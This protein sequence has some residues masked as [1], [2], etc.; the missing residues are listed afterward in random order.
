MFP[1][2]E[3]VGA[4]RMFSIMD[5][6]NV[7]FLAVVSSGVIFIIPA[8]FVLLVKYGIIHTGTLRRYRKYVYVALLVA[9]MFVSP[10]ASPQGNLLLFL[11]MLVM[12]EV[13]MFVG[14]RYE[15]KGTTPIRLFS[16]APSCR[17]CNTELAGNS[18][19]CSHCKRSQS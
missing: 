15:K 18:S 10:G 1:F 8:F 2:F 13:S 4:E 16:T 3:A 11:P 5:F 14:R 12:F 6:Y 17:F 7:L 9:A 19:F